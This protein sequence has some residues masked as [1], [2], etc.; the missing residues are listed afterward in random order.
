MSTNIDNITIDYRIIFDMEQYNYISQNI[1]TLLYNLFN[2]LLIFSIVVYIIIHCI[3]KCKQKKIYS[4]SDY[5]LLI[6]STIFYSYIISGIN[7]K[8]ATLYFIVAALIIFIRYLADI[9]IAIKNNIFND[10]VCSFMLVI[11]ILFYLVS[12]A[13]IREHILFFDWIIGTIAILYILIDIYYLIYIC[14]VFL[15]GVYNSHL[16]KKVFSNIE[17][18]N[19]VMKFIITFLISPIIVLKMLYQ[20]L[21][22]HFKN[23]SLLDYLKKIVLIAIIISFLI[24]YLIV[25][26]IRGYMIVEVNTFVVIVTAIIFPLLM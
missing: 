4:I 2:R 18:Q 8:V 7:F 16:S 24:N 25:S 1:D 6:L 23:K 22:V 3:Y 10:E 17:N 19:S 15:D 11:G 14:N 12:K 5:S 26:K 13:L 20:C 21:L 9:R